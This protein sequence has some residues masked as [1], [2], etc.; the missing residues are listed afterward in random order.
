M[1]ILLMEPFDMTVDRHSLFADLCS[2][3]QEGG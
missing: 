3:S 1:I 2:I